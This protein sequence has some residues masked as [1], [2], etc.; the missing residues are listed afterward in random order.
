MLPSSENLC[1]LN[2]YLKIPFLKK[3]SWQTI[4]KNSEK[5][6]TNEVDI[7]ALWQ[8]KATHSLCLKNVDCLAWF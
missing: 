5:V 7:A 1:K 2:C 3:D 6:K 4:G 8:S